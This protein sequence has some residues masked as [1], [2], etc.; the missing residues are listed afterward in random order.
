MVSA[1]IFITFQARLFLQWGELRRQYVSV[2][3]LNWSHITFP[4]W[5]IFCKTMIFDG[6]VSLNLV[7]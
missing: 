6:L 3:D 2:P 7:F 1:L 4:G 5:E